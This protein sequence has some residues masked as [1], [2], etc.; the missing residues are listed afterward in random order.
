VKNRNLSQIRRLRKIINILLKYG[1]GFIATEINKRGVKLF[2]SFIPVKLIRVRKNRF[3]GVSPAA[4]FRMMLEELG[5]AFIKI[6]QVLSTRVD[7]FPPEFIKE[8]VLLQD[9]VQPHPFEEFE[10]ALLKAYDKPVNETFSSFET[11]PLASASLSQVYKATLANGDQVV[12]KIRRPGVVQKIKGDLN[13]IK[14]IARQAELRIPS[15]RMYNITR[16]LDE[17]IRTVSREV[18]YFNELKNIK[19]MQ[20]NFRR[21]KSIYIPRVYEEY[22]RSNIIVIEYIDGIKVSNID[23]LKESGCDLKLLA[24]RGSRSIFRQVFIHGFFHGDPHPGNI[25]IMD[26]NVVSFIDF[27]MMGRFS[28]KSRDL[29]GRL[30]IA[31]ATIDADEFVE[32]LEDM[33]SLDNRAQVHELKSEI[34]EIFIDYFHADMK[35]IDLSELM[36]RSLTI[37]SKYYIVLPA[38]FTLFYK[39]MITTQAIGYILD[40]DFNINR[41]LTPFVKKLMQERYSPAT[42]IKQNIRILRRY[43]ALYRDLPGQLRQAMKLFDKGTLPISLD[44]ESLDKIYQSGFTIGLDISLGVLTASLVIGSSMLVRLSNRLF[45]FAGFAGFAISGGLALVLFFLFLFQ[46]Y[47]RKR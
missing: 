45:Q 38:V 13:L 34:E 27:G 18:D 41:E 29:I 46:R 17:I 30:L 19:R 15:L 9:R 40:P 2:D 24:R 26:D 42:M 8:L 25:F 23:E 7:I 22:S 47:K 4:R 6:G 16:I 3:R 10:Q 33:G 21:S 43:H 14:R 39:V 36:T 32:V 35:Q 20:S 31:F 11:R 37:L 5:P 44:S 28:E 1:F 12:V